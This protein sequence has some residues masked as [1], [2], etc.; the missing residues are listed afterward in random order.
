MPVIA[1]PL[2]ER[3]WKKVDAQG[4]SILDTA[5]WLWTGCKN[6]AGY[7]SISLGGKGAGNRNV[8]RVSWEL[9]FGII[10][11]GFFVC[12]KCDNPSCVNPE[13]L[14][15]GTPK[16]NMTDMIIKGRKRSAL[17]SDASRSKLIEVQVLQIFNDER[18]YTEI[19]KE[20]N[21]THE[22]VGRIKRKKDWNHLTKDLECIVRRKTLSEDLV[23][24]IFIDAR[25]LDV[26]AN[27]FG[28]CRT[29]V[30]N[31]KKKKYHAKTTQ[32]L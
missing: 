25:S 4:P 24:K 15:L 23:L 11:K 30:S 13:H 1:R 26:I 5:C 12:H 32:G 7:G 14:F 20:F 8:N 21:I 6:K 9:H 18:S 3:F 29:T 17:G 10:P 16:E 2:E 31:I 28:I 27:D 19:A 22:Q